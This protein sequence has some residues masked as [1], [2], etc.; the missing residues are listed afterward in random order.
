VT[1]VLETDRLTL[2]PWRLDDA[3]AAL[4]IFGDNEVARWL[5]PALERCRT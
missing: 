4:R 2:R 3:E 1:D 5:S